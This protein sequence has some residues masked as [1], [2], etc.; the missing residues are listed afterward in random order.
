[1]GGRAWTCAPKHLGGCS[2]WNLAPSPCT[3]VEALPSDARTH[4][5]QGCVLNLAFVYAGAGAALLLAL[6]TR[7]VV[8]SYRKRE[9]APTRELNVA[10]VAYRRQR[11]LPVVLVV[12]DDVDSP[13]MLQGLL[14]LEGC[15]VFSAGCW[16]DA[17]EL[18]RDFV[19]D[20]VLVDLHMTSMDGYA[21]CAAFRSMP[22][23][24][25]T[26]IIALSAIASDEHD[27]LRARGEFDM[28]MTK[29]S[30][31]QVLTELVRSKRT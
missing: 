18:A 11:H 1:M 27:R 19:P 22:A 17:L 26:T 30:D 12:D 10:P 24:S 7:L 29:P 16:A 13:E 23:L 6:T 4:F 3:V 14:V 28:L 31:L 20:V 15:D 25:A 8:R 21:V 9:S 5:T 2:A